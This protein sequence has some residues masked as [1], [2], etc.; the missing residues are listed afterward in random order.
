AA[1]NIISSLVMLVH[2]KGR[3]S[4]ILRTMG[5]TRSTIL[6][7][8]FLTGA[9]IGAVGTLSGVMVG[10]AFTLNIQT[11]Q[12]WVESLFG[13]VF[14]PEIYYLTR[15]PAKI[16]SGEVVTI[17]LISLGLSF[18]ATAYPAWRAARLDPVEALRYE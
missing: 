9:S 3:G 18:L 15:L 5:S 10:V 12:G 1:F 11:I 4:A 6:R 17:A 2:D 13:Q 14:P 8:F 16:D 7:I